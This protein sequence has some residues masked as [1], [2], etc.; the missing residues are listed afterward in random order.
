MAACTSGTLVETFPRE[1]FVE[2]VDEDGRTLEIVT[3]PYA[4]LRLLDS[5]G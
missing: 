5:D 2:I 4:E 3:A 1:G